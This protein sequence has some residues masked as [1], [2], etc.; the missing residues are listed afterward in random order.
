[1][2]EYDEV[3]V[4][5]TPLDLHS[6]YPRAYLRNETGFTH[7]PSFPSARLTEDRSDVFTLKDEIL[8]LTL[9]LED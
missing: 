9:S 4:D 3:R 1:M 5:E 8:I 2:Y 7:L 6:V